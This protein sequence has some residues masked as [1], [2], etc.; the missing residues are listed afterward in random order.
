M[1]SAGFYR[2]D[3]TISNIVPSVID[4]PKEQ[5]VLFDQN[6]SLSAFINPIPDEE[7]ANES[8]IK[9]K[10]QEGSEDENQLLFGDSDQEE[11]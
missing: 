11:I 2:M 3:S 10:A 7:E 6:L 1:P 8:S 5:E 4:K 9:V